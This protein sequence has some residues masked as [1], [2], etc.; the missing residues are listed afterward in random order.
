[1]C[2]F[3]GFITNNNNFDN[4][5][6][7]ENITQL[8]EH[9][10]PDSKG[11]FID[12]NKKIYLGHRRLSILDLSAKGNQP[13]ID[14]TKNFVLGFNGEIYN[15]LELRKN[16]LDNHSFL[17]QSDTETLLYLIIN[18]GID[19]TLEIIDGMFSFI[20]IDLIKNNFII[21]R[22]RFGEKPLY[23]GWSKD[24]FLFSSELKSIIQNPHFD[25]T[26][27]PKVLN[28]YLNLNY[29]P[30]PYSIY[31][32]IFKLEAATYKKFNIKSNE[33]EEVEKKNYWNLVQ[34]KKAANSQP[35]SFYFNDPVNQIQNSLEH[36]VKKQLISDV[37]IGSFLSGGID[38][39]LITSIMQKHSNSKVNTF[40]IGFEQNEYDES[41]F[42]QNIAN[43]IGT[44]HHSEILTA[45]KSL[46]L[47]GS[48]TKV[49]DEPFADS[50]QIPTIFL[51]NITR[52]HVTVALTGDGGDEIFAGY[53]RYLISQFIQNKLLK[54]P[55]KFRLIISNLIKTLSINSW[56]KFFNTAGFLI[57]KK[58]NYNQKGDKLHKLAKIL[59]ENSNLEV[60]S[61]LISNWQWDNKLLNVDDFYND[62]PLNK[63]E[64]QDFN[65]LEQ[66]MIM[67]AK[68]Y[69][70]DDILVKVDRASMYSSLETR[71][72]FLD[73]N[74]VENTFKIRPE[75]FIKKNQGKWILRQILN[76]FVPE[77]LFDRPKKGFG[78][79]IGNWIKNEM[80]DWAN[81][82]LSKNS[83]NHHGFLNYETVKQLLN[84]HTNGK[85]NY[86]Y[87]L[88]NLLMFQMW[89]EEYK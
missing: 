39:S 77:N 26:I 59:Q 24:N 69:L 10:G 35:N 43:Y 6:I 13:M 64:I 49:Y 46:D 71:V 65:N 75:N 44:N 62:F 14:N 18:L 11:L 83:I 27:D 2:G 31:K 50:S 47:I 30:S 81:D 67:D 87:K 86:E 84:D 85:S 16:Y 40:S 15:H 57:P 58:I 32:N 74:L 66:M 23:Y 19:K 51:S 7:L 70:V 17:G 8:L 20:F 41:A 89:Y 68:N 60:Y 79:P 54:I 88:W 72:P 22:D 63:S 76:K 28:L 9:R 33:V 78:I 34:L 29:I 82:L 61:S 1:M 48:I 21:A 37:P 4:N 42:A 3:C 38:S 52:K 25:K 55:Y 73:K 56:D 12:K 5:N 53:N 36:A 80:N 45:K